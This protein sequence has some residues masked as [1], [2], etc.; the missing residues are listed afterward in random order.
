MSDSIAI[1]AVRQAIQRKPGD[2]LTALRLAALEQLADSGLPTT[3]HEDWKYTDLADVI[4]LSNQSLQIEKSDAPR[5]KVDTASIEERFSADWIVL[6]N[7]AID[8][9]SIDRLSRPGLTVSLLSDSEN[10]AIGDAPLS[11]LNLAL[12]NDGLCITID[13]N[14]DDQRPLGLLF[15]DAVDAETGL[16]NS[17]VRIDVQADSNLSLIE[18]H[19]STGKAAHY[20]NTVLQLSLAAGARADVVRIQDR[21]TSHSQTGLSSVQL[22]RDSRLNHAAFDLG[23]KLIRNDLQIELAGPESEVNFSGLYLGSGTRH[24]DNHTRVDHRVGPAR[25]V[26]E[27]RGI[28]TERSRCVWNG[29]A[30]VHDG[31]DGTDAQQA[32][33]NLLLSDKAEIDAKP[34]LEIY[35][36]DVKCSHGTTVGQLDDEALFYLRTRGIDEADAKQMMMR[37]FAQT[38]VAQCPITAIRD[39]IAV[40]VGNRVLQMIAGESK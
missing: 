40:M 21:S 18:Y 27:Y 10:I 30:V 29:K 34:E 3:R 26:Q 24:I 12:L 17:R 38:I 7:G 1:D 13:R 6:E 31:A 15:C 11:A 2:G 39:E 19:A 23:G 16:S 36:D 5:V 32:N 33:H 14:F 8:R 4:Q 25:S 22:L 28:A 20:A 35:A 9:A 37:A